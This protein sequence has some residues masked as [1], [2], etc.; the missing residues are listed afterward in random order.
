MEVN[1]INGHVAIGT[2]DGEL[3]IRKS[4]T[5]ISATIF[6]KQISPVGPNGWIEVVRYSPNGK[7][8]AVGSHDSKI[9]I[10][11]VDQGYA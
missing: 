6:F 1:P 11:D 7:L 8:L 9:Y 4:L 5:D 2:N 10:L 3:Y